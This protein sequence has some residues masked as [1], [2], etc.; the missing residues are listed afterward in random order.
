M[1]QNQPIKPMMRTKS[2]FLALFRTAPAML[3]SPKVPWKLKL[4]FVGAVVLYWVLPDLLPFMP[5]D[6]VFFTLIVIRWFSQ[7]AAKYDTETHS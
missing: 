2:R 7:R 6:D 1:P 4:L 3:F 5:I